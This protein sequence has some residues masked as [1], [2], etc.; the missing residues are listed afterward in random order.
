M[1]KK[2]HPFYG[3]TIV[4]R[5]Q[6]QLVEAILEKYRHDVANE[7]LKEKIWND[8]QMAKYRGEITMPFQ[9]VLRQDP[10]KVFPDAVEVILDTKV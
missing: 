9:V 6:K 3:E 7:A 4:R 1:E 5:T 10:T 8:L 2:E